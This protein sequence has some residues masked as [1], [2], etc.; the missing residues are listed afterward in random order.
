MNMKK[1]TWFAI[2]ESCLLSPKKDL[3]KF[4]EPTGVDHYHLSIYKFP[5]KKTFFK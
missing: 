4:T 3:Q 5:A 2:L 1:K